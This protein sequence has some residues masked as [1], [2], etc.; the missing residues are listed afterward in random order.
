MRRLPMSGSEPLLDMD[1]WATPKAIR[2]APT[3]AW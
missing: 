3:S 1:K 2:M